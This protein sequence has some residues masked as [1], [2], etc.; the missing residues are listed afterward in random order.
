MSWS[1]YCDNLV[2]SGCVDKAAV[3]GLDDGG[4]WSQTA[5]FNLNPAEV[6][7]VAAG[8]RNPDPIRANGINLGGTKYFCL[9]AEDAAIQGK[10]GNA[11]VSIAKS[12]KCIIIGTYKD[13]QQP[14]NCRKQV[15]AIRDYL[16]NSGY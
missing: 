2:A 1:S 3:C 9:A 12:G 7:A 16:N 10:K 4:V 8:F 6:K 14:G 11:G 5:G 13:G 15:E